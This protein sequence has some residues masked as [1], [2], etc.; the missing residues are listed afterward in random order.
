ML[1]KNNIKLSPEKVID[2]IKEIRQLKYVLPK[3]KIVKTKLLKP[4]INQSAILKMNI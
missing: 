2:E 3:T 4:T 1:N